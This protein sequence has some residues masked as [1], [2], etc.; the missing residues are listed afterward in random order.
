MEHCGGCWRY[1][2][3]WQGNAETTVFAYELVYE[4][5]SKG[6]Y[7][8]VCMLIPAVKIHEYMQSKE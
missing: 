8:Y 1:T 7:V 5:S 6:T 2:W 4:K 3:N